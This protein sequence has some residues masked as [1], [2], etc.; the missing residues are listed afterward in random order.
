M[1]NMLKRLIKVILLTVS[2]FI[3]IF[4]V[5]IPNML[6]IAPLLYILIGKDY[7][8]TFSY[9]FILIDEVLDCELLK[10]I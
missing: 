10:E 7:V 1:I 2:L 6:V 8:D 5:A 3:S 4:I 9:S